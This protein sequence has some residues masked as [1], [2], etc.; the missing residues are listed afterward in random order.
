MGGI[1]K[2]QEL[3]AIFDRLRIAG[4]CRHI[5]P[6]IRLNVVE[7]HTVPLRKQQAVFVLG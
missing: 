2:V 5:D 4:L 6:G 1:E 7:R 3:Q